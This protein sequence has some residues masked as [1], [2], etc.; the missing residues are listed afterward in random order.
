[1][2]L[3]QFD[4]D[5]PVDLIAQSPLLNGT[6]HAFWFSIARPDGSSIGRSATSP[7]TSDPATSSSSTTPA[8]CRRGFSVCL[9]T[10]SR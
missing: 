8:S 2:L 6:P 5:L 9:T 3:S 1:M 7:S 4:Y 10:A